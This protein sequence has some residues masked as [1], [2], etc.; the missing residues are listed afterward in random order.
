MDDS[1]DYSPGRGGLRLL[2][3]I[4][5][6]ALIGFTAVRGCQ[7]GPFGRHQIVGMNPEQEAALGAQSYKQVLS[8]SHVVRNSPVVEVVRKIAK[9]LIVASRNP[10]FV[11]YTGLQP[12]DFEWACNVVQS[13]EV[14]AFCLPGGKIVVYTGILPVAQTESA[15]RLSWDMRSATPWPITV[16][17]GW[18]SSKWCRLRNRLPPA[19]FPTWIRKGMPGSRRDGRRRQVWRAAAVQPQTRI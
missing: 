11:K 12:P 16:R 3:I 19:R 5:G 10:E 9:E 1:S 14:N 6:V 7:Q 8:E 15:W 4:I 2:P 18:P 17:S 13:N